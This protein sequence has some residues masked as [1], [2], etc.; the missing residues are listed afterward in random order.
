MPEINKELERFVVDFCHDNKVRNVDLTE[1]SAET[2][3]DLDLNLFDLSIDLFVSDFITRFKLDHSEF[4]WSTYGYPSPNA[5]FIVFRSF[6][7]KLPWVK[8]MCRRAYQPKITL[9]VFQDAMV[10][11]MLR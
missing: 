5:A 1:L 8:R 11:G 7:Y 6:N 2:S 4:N 9:G 3:L 10:T